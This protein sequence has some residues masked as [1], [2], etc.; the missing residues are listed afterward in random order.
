MALC[1]VFFPLLMHHLLISPSFPCPGHWFPVLRLSSHV[2]ESASSRGK[3]CARGWRRETEVF[4]DP[5]TPSSFPC[6]FF[7]KANWW[8]SSSQPWP[9]YSRICCMFFTRRGAS[10]PHCSPHRSGGRKRLWGWGR[11]AS[12]VVRTSK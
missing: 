3:C 7:S 11:L 8:F 1:D 9:K 2:S 5:E 4:I 6:Y 10:I 12:T